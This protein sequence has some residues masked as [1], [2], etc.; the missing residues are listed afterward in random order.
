MARKSLGYVELEWTCPSCGHRNPGTATICE[1]CSAPQPDDVKFE[2]PAQESVS[3]D[4][5]L[6]AR[7]AAGPDVHC[8]FCGTR[9]PADAAQCS[10]CFADLTDAERRDGDQ[11]LGAHRDEAAPEVECSY[12]GAVNPA[13]ARRCHACDSPLGQPKTAVS[14]LSKPKPKT[15]RVPSWVWIVVGVVVLGGCGLLASLLL[16]T[17]E[18]VATVQAVNWERTIAIE[19]LQP[20]SREDW[21][22]EIP[23]DADIGACRQELYDTSA[24]PVANSVEVCGTP[25]T[26]DTGTG[27]GEV[28]QDCQYEVYADR[29]EYSVLAWVVVETAV[30]RGSDLQPAW[31]SLNLLGEQRAGERG[32][33]YEVVFRGDGRSYNYSPDS[34]EEYGRFQPGS[35][36]LIEVN[37][38]GGVVSVAP[39]Q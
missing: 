9:N 30:D 21:R 24:Q 3:Q 8:P 25:Y 7:A 10:Q 2:Q 13:T 17:E 33:T 19:A 28:V 15:S 6:A 29:C 27:V 37:G 22:D 4:A 1:R 34:A 16:R 32:E 12:C 23:A 26:V 5:A 11:V 20:V 35:E 31:P 39:A 18:A 14:A 38:L 36:W